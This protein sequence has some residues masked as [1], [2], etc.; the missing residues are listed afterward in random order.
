MKYVHRYKHISS[1]EKY[2]IQS[3]QNNHTKNIKS[4]N[5]TLNSLGKIIRKTLRT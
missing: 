1:H 5:K 3:N 4:N 2:E